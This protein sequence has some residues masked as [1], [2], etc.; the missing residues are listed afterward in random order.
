M[1]KVGWEDGI[2]S[3][4]DRATTSATPMMMM[5]IK[6]AKVIHLDCGDDDDGNPR[7]ILA[8]VS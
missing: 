1:S 4:S 3:C 8:Q 2:E 6:I 5:M 7:A